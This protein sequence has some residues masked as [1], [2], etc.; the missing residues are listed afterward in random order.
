MTVST[1]HSPPDGAQ[2]VTI[3][4]SALTARQLDELGRLRAVGMEK[5]RQLGGAMDGLSPQEVTQRLCGRHGLVGEF[6]RVARA[7]RQVIRLELE[8]VGLIPA[9]DRE[10]AEE[11][12]EADRDDLSERRDPDPDGDRPE[13]DDVRD[14]VDYRRGPL[15]VVVASVRKT[16][17][18]E[19]PP[20][21]PFAAPAGR[22]SRNS[23]KRSS[24]PNPPP[25]AKGGDCVSQISDLRSLRGRSFNK[26][27]QGAKA[28]ASPGKAASSA[29]S[30]LLSGAAAMPALPI[31]PRFGNR[32]PPGG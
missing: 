7:V 28:A 2:R 22:A 27:G 26:Q 17:G 6:D 3:D 32:G 21:D 4:V 13:R 8:L 30:A 15:D 12:I 25:A 29:K 20:D 10:A 14:P 19:A 24:P 5:T 1:D 31:G 16:L 23:S 18:V 9:V 11:E